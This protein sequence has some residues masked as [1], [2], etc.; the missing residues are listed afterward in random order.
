MKQLN[1]IPPQIF[2]FPL[3]CFYFNNGQT[4]LSFLSLFQAPKLQ[5]K[6]KKSAGRLAEQHQFLFPYNSPCS[7]KPHEQTRVWR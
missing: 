3:F 2:I 6:N 7:Y 4:C 1:T 5:V